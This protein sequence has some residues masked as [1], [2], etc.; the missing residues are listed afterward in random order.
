MENKKKI[1]RLHLAHSRAFLSETNGASIRLHEKVLRIQTR[2]R[3]YYE[4][5]HNIKV[6]TQRILT[7]ILSLPP[8]FLII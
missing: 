1:A 3:L 5:L 6:N 2:T 8:S 7:L 4:A